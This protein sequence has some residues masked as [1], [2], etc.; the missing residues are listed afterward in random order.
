M[1]SNQSRWIFGKVTVQKQKI[2]I[3]INN[4]WSYS[5]TLVNLVVH[6]DFLVLKFRNGNRDNFQMEITG[7]GLAQNDSINESIYNLETTLI[8]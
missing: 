6:I 5:F 7:H 4:L 2:A 1:H 8:L 3:G